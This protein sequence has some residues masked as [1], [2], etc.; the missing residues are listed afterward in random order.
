MGNNQRNNQQSRFRP[1]ETQ[2]YKGIAV[3]LLL[4]HHGLQFTQSELAAM[5]FYGWDAHLYFFTKLCVGIFALVSGYGLCLSFSKHLNRFKAQNLKSE[6]HNRST[7]TNLLQR[8]FF[9]YRYILSRIIKIMTTYWLAFLIVVGLGV[10]IH[11]NLEVIYPDQT[12][13]FFLNDFFALSWLA[14]TPK[15]VNSWWYVSAIVIYYLFFPIFY[16]LFERLK[17]FKWVGVVMLIVFTSMTL[18]L[19]SSTF[20]VYGYIFI[21]GVI[22]AKWNMVES[23]FVPKFNSL[24]NLVLQGVGYLIMLGIIFLFRH[25]FLIH[26]SL[27]NI[28]FYM[29]DGIIILFGIYFIV[30]LGR[31]NWLTKALTFLGNYSFEIFLTHAF[32][33]RHLNF[34][35]YFDHNPALI[36]IRLFLLPLSISQLT[37]Y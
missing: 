29:L 35:I 21:T 24:K 33:I 25:T 4:M 20:W 2:I 16:F 37:I 32:F 17:R 11:G 28:R 18:W 14:K 13:K 15:F 5:P 19:K 6:F 9:S 8:L 12:V 1:A 31:I 7:V 26:S 10:I 22:A 30:L 23:F 36:L 34:V 27:S 3:I